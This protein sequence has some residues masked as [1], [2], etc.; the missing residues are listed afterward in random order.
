MSICHFIYFYQVLIMILIML[1]LCIAKS[2]EYS[3]K[4]NI[5]CQHLKTP[6]PWFSWKILKVVKYVIYCQCP[7]KIKLKIKKSKILWSSSS[8]FHVVLPKCIIS[9]MSPTM[10]WRCLD[11]WCDQWTLESG[12]TT[13]HPIHHPVMDMG[14]QSLTAWGVGRSGGWTNKGWG[15]VCGWVGGDG[16]KCVRDWGQG[17]MIW[18]LDRPQLALL[19]VCVWD[20]DGFADC[21]CISYV[22]HINKS[23]LRHLSRIFIL[24]L[25]NS[26]GHKTT[27]LILV[28]YSSWHLWQS[29]PGL[30]QMMN[31]VIR[32]SVTPFS[33]SCWGVMSLWEP[34][35]SYSHWYEDHLH[36]SSK[37]LKWG[38]VLSGGAPL[39]WFLLGSSVESPRSRHTQ[40]EHAHERE[41]GVR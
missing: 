3:F 15:R 5:N 32:S 35:V 1:Q 34:L 9:V 21:L 6:P 40:R 29:D 8:L 7:S 24:Q 20:E 41:R 22:W 13:F 14:S 19:N 39:C 2:L 30:L 26:T 11:G 27:L 37:W 31:V 25:F 23:A 18:V 12:V 4:H 16:E 36:Q 38:W 10:I 28:Q 17:Y 33:K